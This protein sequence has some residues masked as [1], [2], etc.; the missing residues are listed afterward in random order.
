MEESED[1]KDHS[2]VDQD[3][4]WEKV[5]K[6]LQ[7]GVKK[8]YGDANKDDKSNVNVIDWVEQ[9]DTIFSIRMS[10][11]EGGRLNL[12]RQILGGSALKW[13]NRKVTEL[14]E[15]ADKGEY[16]GP[17]EWNV[18]RQPFIDAHLGVN[19]V[20]TF[21]AELRTLRLGSDECPTP[22]ELNKKFDHVAELAYPDRTTNSM[23]SVL[24]DEYRAIIAASNAFLYKNVE[25][26][27]APTT[28]EEW[29]RAVA[30][31][32]A[33]ELN[34]QSTFAQLPQSKTGGQFRGRGKGGRG[35]AW[36]GRGGNS[37]SSSP[38][39]TVNAMMFGE[40]TGEEGEG[41]GVEGEMNPQLNA[42]PRVNNQRGGRGGRGGR[43]R[44]DGNGRSSMPQELQQ[45]YNER[46]CF[47]CKQEGHTQFAC[48]VPPQPRNEQSKE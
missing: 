12:V 17:I 18:L 20:E 37:S 4:Q 6:A 32:W 47:R 25:R 38:Q 5:S 34:I 39:Q 1:T 30:R 24:G 45:L 2:W 8:F 19:T 35:G 22:S 33:A 36:R 28:L 23:A 11:R 3:K 40:S 7:M 42:V 41:Q 27:A 29:K 48:P 16:F 46:R 44:G 9:V 13:M 10:N 31:H 14:K 21:K 26:S 43:G 15:K